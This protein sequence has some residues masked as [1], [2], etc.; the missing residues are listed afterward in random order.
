MSMDVFEGWR[1][2]VEILADK[3]LMNDIRRSLRTPRSKLKSYKN[4]ADL[5]GA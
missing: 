2:T 1:E 4:A 5:L 3:K